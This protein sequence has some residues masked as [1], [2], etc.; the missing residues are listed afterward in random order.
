M[1]E[2]VAAFALAGVVGGCILWWAYNEL[3]KGIKHI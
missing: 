1:I 3:A 2:I